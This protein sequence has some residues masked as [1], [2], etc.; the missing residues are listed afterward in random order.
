MRRAAFLALLLATAA[1]AQTDRRR[2]GFDDM[3][4]Q[5]QAMQRDDTQNPAMLWPRATR[6]STPHSNAP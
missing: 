1:E 4:P 5:T 2:S 6:P 3:S